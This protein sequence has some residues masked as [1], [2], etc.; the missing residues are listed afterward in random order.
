MEEVYFGGFVGVGI[1][2][3]LFFIKGDLMVGNVVGKLG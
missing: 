2:F 1:K 3:D